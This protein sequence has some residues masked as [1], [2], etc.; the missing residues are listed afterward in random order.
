MNEK[1]SQSFILST[2]CK[3]VTGYS[4]LKL[5]KSRLK[6]KFNATYSNSVK[7]MRKVSGMKSYKLKLQNKD[8][9]LVILNVHEVLKSEFKKLV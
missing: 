5:G 2:I 6:L 1:L 7:S 8:E 4:R 3:S 9:A